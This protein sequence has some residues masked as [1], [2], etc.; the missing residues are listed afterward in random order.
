MLYNY[1][2]LL[3]YIGFNM[4]LD[5]FDD[6]AMLDLFDIDLDLLGLDLLDFDLDLFDIDL[7][8]CELP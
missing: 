8:L 1:I 6:I 3:F 2:S 5:N 4:I 7:S